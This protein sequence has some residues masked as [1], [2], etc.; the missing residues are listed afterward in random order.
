MDVDALRAQP[1]RD[2]EEGCTPISVVASAG[3]VNTGTIDPFGE[4]LQV[5]RGKHV[6]LHMDGAYGGFGLL[7]PTIAYLYEGFAEAD[8]IAVDPHKRRVRRGEKQVLRCHEGRKSWV[9]K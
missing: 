1:R 3:T 7:D 9:S 6:W 2:K 5:G 4:I 8:S